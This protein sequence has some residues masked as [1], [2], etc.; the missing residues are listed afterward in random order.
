[1]CGKQG[2]ST[3]GGTVILSTVGTPLLATLGKIYQNPPKFSNESL[4]KLQVKMGASDNDMKTVGNFLRIHCGRGSVVKLDEYMKERN[5]MLRDKFEVKKIIQAEYVNMEVDSSEFSKQKKKKDTTLVVKCVV[6]AKHVGDLA[7]FIIE[8][9]NFTP[10]SSMVQIGID[11][12]QSLLN[13]M[14]VKEKKW[15]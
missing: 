10:S 15:I 14:S 4:T 13:I 7:C 8:A 12:S 9:R 11:D 5:N 2:I 3:Q 6:Y 1:M